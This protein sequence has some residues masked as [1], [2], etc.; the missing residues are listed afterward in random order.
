LLARISD[1]ER[2]LATA[3]ND[4]QRSFRDGLNSAVGNL[5]TAVQNAALGRSAQSE[6]AA[7][8]YSELTCQGGGTE[9]REVFR[10]QWMKAVRS[11]GLHELPELRAAAPL[12][13]AVD[14]RP[15]TADTLP[16][17]PVGSSLL[18]LRF[19]LDEAFIS[20]DDE[21][22]YPIDNP[23][24][25]DPV[26]G[27]PVVSPAGWKGNL[28]WAAAKLWADAAGTPEFLAQE[29]FRMALLFGD[30]TGEESGDRLA[31][32]LDGCHPEAA[33]LYRE[34]LR[35]HFNTSGGDALPHHAGRLEFFPTFFDRIGFEV[36][37]PHDRRRRAGTMPIYFESVPA[38]T[39]GWF[40]LVYV[41]FDLVGR[42]P[43]EIKATLEGDLPLL[44]RTLTEMFCVYG[45]SAKKTSGFGVAK[46]GP[47]T[48]QGQWQVGRMT[49]CVTDL[50]GLPGLADILVD[51]LEETLA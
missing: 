20:R 36:I 21:A 27:L 28:R 2:Q 16:Q 50:A 1:I 44:A 37:N 22:F 30:E 8:V 9:S 43:A 40:T 51:R 12:L 39:Q 31:G 10:Q 3:R 41:P 5:W 23:V 45:F 26:F 17:L 15:G 34:M 7:A 42:P 18:H 24:R 35:R 6:L 14:N 32:Y 13:N 47:N 4:Q 49:A 33:A 29:R 38:G 11:E 19:T 46:C 25:K 48:A